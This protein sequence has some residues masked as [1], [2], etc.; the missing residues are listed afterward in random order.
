MQDLLFSSYSV[1]QGSSSSTKNIKLFYSFYKPDHRHSTAWSV[2][3]QHGLLDQHHPTSHKK[4]IKNRIGNNL[5]SYLV[6]DR[7]SSNEL[8]VRSQNCCIYLIIDEVDN[9]LFEHERWL[10]KTL[11]SSGGGGIKLCRGDMGSFLQCFWEHCLT[12]TLTEWKE[13]SE[14]NTCIFE[15]KTIITKV[16][17]ET[18][19]FKFKSYQ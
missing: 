14:L 8:H 13:Q 19:G 5:Q 15:M 4:I 1:A 16:Y 6:T 17:P 10:G 7:G 11:H 18:S 12:N 9:S 3:E 2:Q